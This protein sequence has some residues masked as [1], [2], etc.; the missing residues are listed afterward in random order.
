MRCTLGR[1]RRGEA[2]LEE[3]PHEVRGRQWR[4]RAERA[5]S[6]SPPAPP[7][8]PAS[9]GGQAQPT[10]G[11]QTGG[12]GA[13]AR[14]SPQSPSHG[15]STTNMARQEAS[16]SWTRPWRSGRGAHGHVVTLRHLLLAVRLQGADVSPASLPRLPSR[17][18]VHRRT[19]GHLLLPGRRFHQETAGK[20]LPPGHWGRP[21]ARGRRLIPHWGP[22]GTGLEESG[23]WPALGGRAG[24]CSLRAGRGLALSS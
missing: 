24:T 9:V 21:G 8:P 22:G 19:R 1:G 6:S 2:D 14:H 12:G 7:G 11:L 20:T 16:S 5:G 23:G 13:S 17:C 10:P 15:G 3:R 4:P 18:C